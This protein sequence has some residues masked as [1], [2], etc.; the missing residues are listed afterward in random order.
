ME[1]KFLRREYFRPIGNCI[2]FSRY[3][4][5][6][7]KDPLFEEWGKTVLDEE[8]KLPE[9]N[10]DAAYIALAKYGRGQPKL[11]N[12]Q[13]LDFK[14]ALSWLHDEFSFMKDSRVRTFEES[15]AGLDLTTSPGYPFT[16]MFHTKGDLLEQMPEIIEWIEEDWTRLESSDWWCIFQSSQK[17]ELRPAAKVAK[18]SIRNFLASSIEATIHGDRLFGDMNRKLIDNNLI[19]CSTVGMSP[20]SGNW[21]KLITSLGKLKTAYSVDGV[22]YDASLMVRMMWGIAAF[23]WSC[24]RPEDRTAANKRKLVSYY[25]NLIFSYIVTP[26]GNIVQ[27]EGGNPSGSVNTITDNTLCLAV[28]MAYAWIRNCRAEGRVPVYKKYAKN[29]NKKLQGDDN[30]WSTTLKWVR[31]GPSL[32]RPFFAELGLAITSESEEPSYPWQL[33]YLSQRSRWKY[34]MWLPFPDESKMLASLAYI[35]RKNLGHLGTMERLSA[36]YMVGYYNDDLRELLRDFIDWMIAKFSIDLSVE[37]KLATHQVRDEGFYRFLYTERLALQSTTGP[38][39]CGKSFL[40]MRGNSNNVKNKMQRGDFLLKKME[41]GGMISH[42]GAEWLK[43][44]LNPFPD[45]PITD[46]RGVPDYCTEPSV[47]RR[48]KKSVNITSPYDTGNQWSFHVR[49]WPWLNGTQFR[50]YEGRRNNWITTPMPDPTNVLWPI[51]GGVD[52]CCIDHDEDYNG[53]FPAN[54]PPFYSLD[55][56][57]EFTKGM[58]RLVGIGYEISDN[59]A[60]VYRQGHSYHYRQSNTTQQ[61]SMFNVQEVAPPDPEKVSQVSVVPV[62]APMQTPAKAMLLP[63]T[64]D[65]PAEEGVYAVGSFSS[66]NPP[67]FVEYRMPGIPWH[68]DLDAAFDDSETFQAFGGVDDTANYSNYL[69]PYMRGVGD[70]SSHLCPPALKIEAINQNG[71]FFTGLN[72]NASFTLTVHYYIESF[73]SIAEQDILVLAEPSASYDPVALQMYARAVQE[74]PVAVRVGLNPNGEWWAD[75]VEAAGEVLGPLAA[76]AGFPETTPFILG[77]S[78]LAAKVLRPPPS[79]PAPAN[80]RKAQNKSNVAANNAR[81]NVATARRTSRAA[82]RKARKNP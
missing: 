1:A 34:G 2:K 79:L 4:N 69:L 66:I 60:A 61:S 19:S 22:A 78:K 13:E 26:L 77:G 64:V 20:F 81:N 74:L 71:S 36:Y 17:E 46:C 15:F 37:W 52:V 23:R 11:D 65:W 50:P 56:G 10:E 53:V 72:S 45:T 40:E 55:V 28:Y 70:G 35:K 68:S 24:L 58:S 63:D 9:L 39:P 80:Q 51:I 14:L 3:K 42:H 82:G 59:T 32:V 21:H 73:P 54:A 8:W 57:R 18:N 12:E 76:L 31:F 75:V 16:A 67:K 48:I 5:K 41:D 44:A 7:V 49:M 30:I 25:R 43:T 47:F 62:R 33:G 38:S 6:R 27:K 29:V